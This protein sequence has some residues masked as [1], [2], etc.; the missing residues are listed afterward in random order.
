MTAT[1]P[2]GFMVGPP[3]PDIEGGSKCPRALNNPVVICSTV[4]MTNQY[5]GE[6]HFG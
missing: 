3:I 2:K 6:V 1:S 4:S 5:F